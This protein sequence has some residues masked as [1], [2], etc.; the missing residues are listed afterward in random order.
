[1][2]PTSQQDFAF[3]PFRLNP[4]TRSLIRDSDT[5]SMGGRALAVLAVLAS[6]AGE[7]VGKDAL[8]DQV[9]PGLTV[10][11]NNLQV[12]ISALRK[13][14]GEGWIVTVPGR[15]YRL[16]VQSKGDA[17]PARDPEMKLEGPALPDRP[18]I[19]VPAFANMSSEPDQQYFSDG[20]A[21]DIIT[22]LSRNRSLFVIARTSSFT[23][24][25]RS[26][27]VKVIGREL[28]VRYVVEG[29]VRRGSDRIRVTAQLIDAMTGNQL[30][31]E[32][33]DRDVADIFAVQGEI[34]ERVVS[35]IEPELYA[36][37]NVRSQSKPPDSLDAWECVIRA[38]SC[39]SQGTL[40]ENSEAEALCRRAVAI[41]PGYG[42][43]HSLLAWSLLRRSAYSGDL[44]EVVSEVNAETRI[45]LDLDDRDSWAHWVR[46]I[47]FTGLRRFDDAERALRRA[48]DL[49][50]NFALA[51]AFLA[52]SQSSNPTFPRK[53]TPTLAL[54]R[55]HEDAVHGA[56]HALR[57]SPHDRHVGLYASLA[58]ANVHFTAGRYS[59]CARW[60]RNALEKNPG[61]IAGHSLFTATLAME[62]DL[63]AASEA[64]HTLLRLHVGYSLTWMYENQPF[65]GETADRL[66]EGLRRAGGSGVMTTT[67]PLMAILA[68]D[69]AGYSR[70][71]TGRCAVSGVRTARCRCEVRDY[72]SWSFITVN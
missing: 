46:G 20:I 30:W 58:I 69:V 43:A 52:W 50:P 57:L 55:A 48:L 9:W 31:A 25:G 66:S 10:Q 23:Y 56:E 49:N 13:A 5:V 34:T 62:G 42:R 2:P 63:T 44:Q 67:R 36:A 29:S 8:L 33:Y 59:E 19:A 21:G 68:A 17:P 53:S 51:H 38:L 60:A 6:A 15:G 39:M 71:V 4:S 27:D 3:G 32:R 12:Q 28:G 18:S 1:V 65:N 26:V 72:W 54:Q 45:A 70:S 16:A 64:R 37:E 61:H 40:D 47:L 14:L 11:E 22:D 7:T 35:A 41:A 24:K